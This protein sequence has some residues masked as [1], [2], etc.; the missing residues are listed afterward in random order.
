MSKSG[1]DSLT[2]SL[3]LE[4]AEYGIRVN[5]VSPSLAKTD[6]LKKTGLFVTIILRFGV[7]NS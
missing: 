4:L 2:K 3:A 1:L 6:F 5:S 7:R